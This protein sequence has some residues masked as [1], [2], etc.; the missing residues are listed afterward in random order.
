MTLV[1]FCEDEA[2]VL[3]SFAQ[4]GQGIGVGHD[5]DAEDFGYRF[6]R[7][8]VLGRADASA[9]NYDIGA[10]KCD[11]EDFGHAVLVVADA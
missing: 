2:T 9:G 7:K 10:I 8:I 11:A 3:E 6:T 4:F 5:V 1:V